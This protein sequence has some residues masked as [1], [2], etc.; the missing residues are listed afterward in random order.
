MLTGEILEPFPF[1]SVIKKM[2]VPFGVINTI[3]QI[4]IQRAKYET[5]IRCD[6]M[7]VILSF[8]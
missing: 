4:L 7:G 1:T 3:L 6:I 2:S 8:M 5:E